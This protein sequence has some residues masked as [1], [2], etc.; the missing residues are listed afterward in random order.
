MMRIC[1]RATVN[2]ATPINNRIN[3]TSIIRIRKIRIKKK[4]PKS[5]RQNRN[6]RR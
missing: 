5:R 4:F 3:S 2:R 6:N 1:W